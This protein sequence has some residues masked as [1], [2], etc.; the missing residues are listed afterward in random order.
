MEPNTRF[1]EPLRTF[2]IHISEMF[3]LEK[4]RLAAASRQSELAACK[5]GGLSRSEGGGVE[6]LSHLPLM[7]TPT[8]LQRVSLQDADFF[9]VEDGLSNS[10]SK[11]SPVTGMLTYTDV[12]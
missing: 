5:G 9:S 3:D 12:C 10:P 4:E 7:R 1:P 8:K 6:S 11:G 2:A